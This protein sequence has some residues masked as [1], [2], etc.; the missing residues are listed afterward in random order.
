MLSFLEDYG[1]HYLQDIV[2]GDVLYQV[3]ALDRDQYRAAKASVASLGG[4]ASPAD[5][6]RFYNSHLAPWLVRETGKVGVASGDRAVASILESELN[7]SGMFGSYPNLL[8]MADSPELTARLEAATESTEAVVGLNFA[9]LRGWVRDPQ[10]REYYDEI[11]D[12]HM[13]LWEANMRR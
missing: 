8:V 11:V 4:L 9:S 6:G 12:T 1:S 5:F 7:T 10:V 2:V 3:I 13:A